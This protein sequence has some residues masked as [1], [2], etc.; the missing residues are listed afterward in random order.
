MDLLVPHRRPGPLLPGTLLERP[1]R[2]LGIV[3]LPD[4]RVVEA[5]IGDRGRLEDVL[6]PGAEI[7]LQAASS[8][9]RRTAFT[10]VCARAPEGVF[11]SVDPANANRLVR[12]LLEARL[13]PLPTWRAIAQEVRHGSS[14]FDFALELSGGGRLLL[15]V[16]SAG[17][18][19]DGVALFPDAPSERASRHCRELE[20]LATSGEQAAVVL[21]AQ[22]GDAK[23]IAPHPVDPAFAL[24]L[25]DAA[26]AGV[27][28]LGVAFSVE[29]EGFRYL[30][31]IP[32]LFGPRSERS[33]VDSR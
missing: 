31:P 28:V 10:V 20:A 19:R 7:R 33:K 8:P 18:A 4:G 29:D 30:G 24:A 23:A 15:E 25:A 9:T 22:R 5:H 27:R 2:F 26:R 16:K 3:R 1:N 12:A 17:A 32:V 11:T 14:R 21:V 6:R 13:L